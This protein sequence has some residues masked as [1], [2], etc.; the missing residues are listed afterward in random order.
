MKILRQYLNVQ[1]GMVFTRWR[2]VGEVF[3][4]NRPTNGYKEWFVLCECSCGTLRAVRI[5]QLFNGHS[6]SCGCIKRE[7]FYDMSYRHGENLPG[8]RT[9]LY[10]VWDG[11]TQRCLNANHDSYKDYGGRGIGICEEWRDFINFRDWANTHGFH[12]ELQLDRINNNLG[13]FPGNCRWVTE[14]V[15]KRNTRQNHWVTAFGQTKCIEDWARDPLCTVTPSRLRQRMLAWGNAEIAITT[16]R[17]SKKTAP[18][19]KNQGIVV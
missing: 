15:N 6:T 8:K 19:Y 12:P 1:K 14:P 7:Q 13:Y 3:W 5:A 10:R 4:K 16:P 18:S 2:V 9:H 11:M 17:M